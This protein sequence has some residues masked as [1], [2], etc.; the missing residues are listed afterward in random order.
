MRRLPALHN[1]SIWLMRWILLSL[2]FSEDASLELF[3]TGNSSTLLTCKVMVSLFGASLG[4]GTFAFIRWIIFMDDG[5][6]RCNEMP[7]LQ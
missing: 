2:K 5:K 6:Y 7:R 1:D 3:D 4:D